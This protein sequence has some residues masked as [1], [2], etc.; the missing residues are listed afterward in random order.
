MVLDPDIQCIFHTS[1]LSRYLTLSSSNYQILHIYA[2][3]CSDLYN[4]SIFI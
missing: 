4:N 2:E 3:I 1:S